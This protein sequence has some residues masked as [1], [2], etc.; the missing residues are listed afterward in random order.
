MM[1][2]VD[3]APVE[4]SAMLDGIKEPAILL[5]PNYRILAA[6]T[7]YRNIH[8]HGESVIHRHCYEVSHGNETPCGQNNESC[9]MEMARVTGEPQR[10]FHIHHSPR[11]DEHVEVEGRPIFNEQG[12][13]HYFV[14]IIRQSRAASTQAES[15]GMVGRSPAFNRM[16]E[17]VQRVAPSETAALLLGESGTGK[18]LVAQAIHDLSS[19]RDALFVPV[20][21]SGLTE[22]LFESELFGHEKGAFTGAHGAKKGLVD[23]ARGGTLFLDEVGDIPLSL[24]VKLLRL[25]ETGTFRSVGGVDPRQADFRLICAT[26]RNLKE[27]VASGRFRSDLYYR[28]STFPVELPP[29]RQREGDL[30]LLVNTLL[31]RIPGAE[32]KRLSSEALVYLT[33][34]DFPGNI[35]ELKNILERASLMTD[36]DLIKP[37][38]LSDECTEGGEVA[39]DFIVYPLSKVE[40][41]Y[42]A[43]VSVRFS[44]DRKELAEKLGISER[45]LFRKLQKIS[46][47]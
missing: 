32:N 39:P 2:N 19:H 23:A 34:Y 26:H 46:E 1:S 29:L 40:Q 6:N 36:T 4:I 25:L 17:L 37:Q 11:G 12:E 10:V 22:S 13:L 16:L 42:L 33:N 20:E 18:E 15:H 35:R 45:T 21:C 14:E 28:I 5:S 27:M 30:E 8:G 9:P 47:L 41:R 31:H 24:Q 44:G 7:S 43:E 38:H 3:V